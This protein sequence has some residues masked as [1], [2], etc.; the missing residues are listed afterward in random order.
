M[1]GVKVDQKWEVSTVIIAIF[2]ILLKS[3]GT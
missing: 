1:L 2:N 3:A